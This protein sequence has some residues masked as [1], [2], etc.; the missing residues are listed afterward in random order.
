MLYGQAVP[1][2]GGVVSGVLAQDAGKVAAVFTTTAGALSPVGAYTIAAML[3]GR[4]AGDYV[5]GMGPVGSLSIAQAPTLT[6]LSVLT[7]SL[8]LGSVES[9]SVQAVSTTSGVPA[10]SVTVSDGTT[11]L[12]VVG[13]AG[14]AAAF[15]TSTLALGTHHL[16]AAYSGDGN[17]LESTSAVAT[18]TVGVAQDF[19]LASMGAISQAVPA[20]SAATYSFSVGMVGAAMASP[21][22]LAAQGLPVGATASFSPNYIPPGGAVT[23][24]TMTIQTPLAAMEERTRPVAP[25]GSGPGWL[26]VLMLPVWGFLRRGRGRFRSTMW[27]GLGAFMMLAT[28]C[29]DRVN[30]GPEL[31]GAISYTLTVTGTATSATGAALVHTVNVTLQV[32]Q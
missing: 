23:S 20:G 12:G 21:I 14:G 26:A 31:V 28:G 16:S 22:T 17:F 4:A 19:T 1:A 32:L 7:S 25:G 13:L 9:L 30:T 15:S 8:G 24:F 27:L 18:V 2:L 5:L 11:V 10:G 29:G 6:T 3:T